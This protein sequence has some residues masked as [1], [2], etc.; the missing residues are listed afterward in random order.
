[1]PRGP[2]SASFDTLNKFSLIFVVGFP[3][4]SPG[5]TLGKTDFNKPQGL[6]ILKSV[7]PMRITVSA[8]LINQ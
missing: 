7:F 2:D 5:L 6:C 4:L 3:W 8:S 1:M